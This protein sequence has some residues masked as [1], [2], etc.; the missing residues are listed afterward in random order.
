MK[1]EQDCVCW[2]AT[3]QHVRAGGLIIYPTET[4]YALGCLSTLSSAVEDIFRVKE[5]EQLK[6]L[7]LIVADW[8]MVDSFVR[9]DENAAVLARK[10]W[11]GPLSIVVPVTDSICAL[12]RGTDGRAAV[13]MSPHPVAQALCRA[14]GVPLISTSANRS[15]QPPA[16]VPCAVD[17]QLV[18]RPGMALVTDKPWPAGGLPSTLVEVR[19]K[20][21]VRILR[22]GALPAETLW[23]AGYVL[24]W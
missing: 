22:S 9:L 19:G 20:Q 7:P 18:L 12:A 13:R 15:G 1:T 24:E 16:S 4:F 14:L 2:D 3:V 8:D 17:A 23:S 11:P 21:R 10:F 6:S 5:R